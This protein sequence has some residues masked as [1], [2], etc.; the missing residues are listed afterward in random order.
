MS[1]FFMGN[2]LANSG[3]VI[4]YNSSLAVLAAGFPLLS[5]L[6]I[7]ISK[8]DFI[9]INFFKGCATKS[10]HDLFCHAGLISASYKTRN[11]DDL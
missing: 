5:L 4:R 6:Q 9:E 11:S 10:Q 3:Q 8:S 2:P 1:G 7:D